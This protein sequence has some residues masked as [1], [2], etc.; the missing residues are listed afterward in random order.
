MFQSLKVEVVEPVSANKMR[1]DY[2]SLPIPEQE[3]ILGDNFQQ[4]YVEETEPPA[5]LD[6][7]TRYMEIMEK[8]NEKK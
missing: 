1:S 8:K 5:C 6:P 2:E 3:G 4:S 7:N